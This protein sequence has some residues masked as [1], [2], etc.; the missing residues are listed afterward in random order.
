MVYSSFSALD[1]NPSGVRGCQLRGQSQSPEE[2]AVVLQDGGAQPL[3]PD[4]RTGWGEHDAQWTGTWAEGPHPG[5][6]EPPL[7]TKGM[8]AGLGRGEAP[9]RPFTSCLLP[10][11]TQLAAKGSRGRLAKQVR[12]AQPGVVGHERQEEEYEGRDPRG[13][14]Q[15]LKSGAVQGQA[16]ASLG[17]LTREGETGGTWSR[18]AG[19]RCLGAG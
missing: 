8:H 5:K 13:A 18:R 9:P 17:E 3:P 14:L 16:E 11:Q 1:S 19:T 4:T 15:C 12:W 7:E 2:G 10:N 6:D